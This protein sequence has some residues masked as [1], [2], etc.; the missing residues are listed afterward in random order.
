MKRFTL[1]LSFL[2]F[3]IFSLSA[4]NLRVKI[5]GSERTYNQMRI[6]N[7]TNSEN[8]E[9][10]VYSLKQKDGK[11]IAN[12]TLGSFRLKEYDDSDSCTMDLKRNQYVGIVV[13]D[14]VGKVT[15]SLSYRDYPFFDVVEI[16]L[17]SVEFDD[18]TLPSVQVF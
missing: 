15:Y 12:E 18:E 10:T 2:V 4:E 1:L 9:C 14:K 17:T 6:Y 7:N 8:F 5:G 3:G 13:P 16:Y 11:Y